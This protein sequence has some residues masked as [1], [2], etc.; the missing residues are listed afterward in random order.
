MEKSINIT[1]FPNVKTRKKEGAVFLTGE[2]IGRK[3]Q[4]FS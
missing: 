4:T 1:S 3:N 2:I